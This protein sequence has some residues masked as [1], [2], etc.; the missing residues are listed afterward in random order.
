MPTNGD[1]AA[2]LWF[3]VGW[4]SGIGAVF[5]GMILLFIWGVLAVSALLGLTGFSVAGLLR[6]KRRERPEDGG[7]DDLF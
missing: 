6:R 7:L 3:G 2:D 4:F 5:G 1:P